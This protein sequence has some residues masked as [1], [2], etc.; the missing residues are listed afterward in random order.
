MHITLKAT[1]ADAGMISHLLAKN[2]YNLY[3]RTETKEGVRWVW[4]HH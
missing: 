3:D 1:G 2:P 4:V